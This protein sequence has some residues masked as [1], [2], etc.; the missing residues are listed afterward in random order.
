M[1]PLP[2]VGACVLE[3]YLRFVELLVYKRERD[4][5]L[6][7]NEKKEEVHGIFCTGIPVWYRDNPGRF[8]PIPVCYPGPVSEGGA[9]FSSWAD[10]N[11]DNPG[12]FLAIPVWNPGRAQK[13]KL[14]MNIIV[15]NCITEIPRRCRD[16]AN[17]VSNQ[18]Y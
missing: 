3:C 1:V 2:G 8:L 11:W 12:R 10:P 16:V 5:E 13:K 15:M 18:P 9:K 17:V 14:W 4:I 6:K 7:E